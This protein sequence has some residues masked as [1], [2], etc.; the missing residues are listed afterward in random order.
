MPFPKV[1]FRRHLAILGLAAALAMPQPAQAQSG[2]LE[3][4]RQAVFAQLLAAPADRALMLEYAR[5]SNRL[6]DFEAAAATLERFVDLEPGDVGARVEL[7]IAYFSL[8][9]Y[10]VARYHLAAADASGALT[11]EQAALVARYRTE[12]EARDAPSRFSGEVALGQGHTAGTGDSGLYGSVALTWRLDLGGPNA[13]DW[14]TQ[15]SHESFQP[16]Q[17]SFG[18]RVVTRLRTG[19]EF[20]LAGDAFGPRLQPYLELTRLRDGDA[21]TEDYD[22]LAFGL[23]YQNPHSATL[24]SLADLQIGRGEPTDPTQDA[25]DMW[26]AMAGLAVR[27]SR[28]TRIRGLLRWREERVDATGGETVTRSLQ[29]DARHSFDLG[30][31]AAGAV[32]PRDWE[33]RGFVRQSL[34]EERLGGFLVADTRDTSYGLALRAFVT[35]D[36]FVELQGTRLDRE[37]RLG[38]GGDLD[39]TFYGL[40]IGWEF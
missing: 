22:A 24:T 18:E 30:G 8:G 4:R 29:I 15:L 1:P 9:A 7:A 21:L 36:L 3:T 40:Q 16:G 31:G 33:I 13:T 20:R 26:M 28:D 2:D 39:E 11:P 14:L 5:L 37:D 12:A 19:P 35:E 17:F 34:V 27:P 32:L 6:R 38:F 23:A 25:F 10:G